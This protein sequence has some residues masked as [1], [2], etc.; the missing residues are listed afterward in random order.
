MDL[1]GDQRLVV[2]ELD[3]FAVQAKS[4]DRNNDGLISE[5]EMPISVLLEVK[6]PEARGLRS[7]LGGTAIEKR[8]ANEST[9]LLGSQDGLYI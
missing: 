1:N 4:W 3:Q 9:A 7:R 5:E 2:G 8:G 6:R